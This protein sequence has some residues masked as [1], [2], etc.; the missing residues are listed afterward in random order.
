MGHVPRSLGVWCLG[1]LTRKCHPGDVVT[2]D[3]IFLPLRDG[4]QGYMGSQYQDVSQL[5]TGTYLEATGIR[6]HKQSYE[7]IS[8][9]QAASE[10]TVEKMEREARILS[11]AQGEDPMGV[12]SKSIAPEIFGHE[13]IKRALLLQLVGG[14]TRK[15]PDGM[16]IRGDINIW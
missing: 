14:C 1:E 6:I 8:K 13:D 9:A 15:L 7:D 12:L 3:G 2:L 4:A 10:G 16:R 11:V 5:V